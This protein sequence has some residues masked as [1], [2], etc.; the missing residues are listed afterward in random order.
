MTNQDQSCLRFSLEES[1]W[2][3]KGQEVSELFSLSIEPKVSVTERNQYVVIEGSLLVTGEYQG[4][5]DNQEW[6]SENNYN[7]LMHQRY[8]Q[9]VIRREDNGIF[10][11]HHT[12]PVDISIPTNRVVDRSAIEV[13]IS[14]F[15]YNMP[16]NSCIKLMAELIITGIYDGD[17]LQYTS[18]EYVPS[19]EREEYYEY[20]LEESVTYIQSESSYVQAPE[21]YEESLTLQEESYYEQESIQRQAES[22]IE[23]GIMNQYGQYS[24]IESMMQPESNMNNESLHYQRYSETESMMQPESNMNNESLHYQRYSETESMMQPESNVNNESFHFQQYSEAESMM[25]PESNMNN[26]SFHYQRYSEAESMLQPESNMNNESLTDEYERYSEVESQ[27]KQSES[28]V[29]NESI[30]SIE[31]NSELENDENNESLSIPLGRYNDDE[32][33]TLDEES[34]VENDSFYTNL[35]SNRESESLQHE[36]Y[37]EAEA[38][39]EDLE[40]NEEA[41]S[42][43]ELESVSLQAEKSLESFEAS[44]YAIPKEE[45]SQYQDV[46]LRAQN[47]TLENKPL[48]FQ[49]S[50][51]IPMPIFTPPEIPSYPKQPVVNA[52]EEEVNQP[53]DITTIKNDLMEESSYQTVNIGLEEVEASVRNDSSREEQHYEESSIKE[54]VLNSIVRNEQESL[55]VEQ[56]NKRRVEESIQTNINKRPI[57]KVEDQEVTTQKAET[58]KLSVSLTDFF[59]KKETKT[60]TRLKVCIVQSGESLSDLASRYD[61][62]KQE[63]IAYNHLEDESEVEGGKVLYIPQKAIHK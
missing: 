51:T 33:Q 13:D 6:E 59:A 2:F 20:P 15:D 57:Y 49:S 5:N 22:T 23:D 11:F 28:Y 62:S 42:Y 8:I 40:R 21:K 44:A 12:F 55:Q 56:A 32:S 35:Y 9:N 50:F 16:E 63:I 37:D 29:D 39:T 36:S 7:Q 17:Q 61:I 38:V 19:D 54:E 1:I 18:D 46:Q 34:N 26:E 53:D 24:E 52:R 10:L 58:G 41:E 43:V 25:Q 27:M 48:H 30:A 14:S 47:T 4:V 3:R 45:S 60:Q 31:R